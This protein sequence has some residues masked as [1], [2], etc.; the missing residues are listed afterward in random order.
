MPGRTWIIAPDKETLEKRW[1]RLIAEKNTDAKAVLFHPHLRKNKKKNKDK[2]EDEEN[3][4]K[5]VPGD[6]YLN[7]PLATG[8]VGHEFRSLSV[9]KDSG[10]VIVPTRYAFR[11]LDRQWIIPDARLINQSNPTLWKAWSDKQIFVTGLDAHSPTS[12][13][14]LTLCGAIPDLHHYKGSFG[15]RVYPL[16]PMRR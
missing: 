15:G 11:S 3:K 8:L 16:W 5:Y 14:A 7:K 13:P 9:D 10:K 12:G 6:K 2:K 4:D 1:A